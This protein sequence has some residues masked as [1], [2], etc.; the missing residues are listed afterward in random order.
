MKFASLALVLMLV[1]WGAAAQAFEAAGKP[2][3]HID[4]AAAGSA[5]AD[6]SLQRPLNSLDQL[7]AIRFAP[8]TRIL[9]KRGATCHGSFRPKAGSSGTAAT[10][11]V[12][13]S[14][15]NASAPRAAIAAGCRDAR[16]DPQ[17][18]LT[19]AS[20]RP[21]GV[22]PYHSLCTT[23]DGIVNRAAVHLL[24]VEYW[25]I[26]GLELSNDGLDEAGRVGLLVQLENFGTGHHYRINDVYVHH[27]RGYLKDE[28]NRK[29]AYK[30]TGGILFDVTRDGELPGAKQKHTNFD[31]VLVENSEVYHV[32]GIG[33]SNR[34]AW[35]CRPR[36]APCGDFPPYKG[37]P[38]Y[39][40]DPATDAATDFYPST[41][42]VFRNNKIHDIGGDGLIVRTALAPLVEAN[43]LHDIWMRAPGNSAGAWAINTDGAVFQY[44]EVHG[45]RLPAGMN[46]GM[47]FD[48]DM[49]TRQTRI[50]ANYSHD[51]AGGLMLFCAC[52]K[53]GLGQQAMTESVVVER[54]L[55]INDRHR[56]ILVA[57][58]DS[59]V[60][61]DN[62]IVTDSA[63]PLLESHDYG[64]S[65]VLEMRGNRFVS[66]GGSGELY[67]PNSKSGSYA[68]FVW[69]DNT[70]HGYQ[71]SVQG[72]VAMSAASVDVNSLVAQW[73]AATQFRQRGYQPR[74]K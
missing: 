54:N 9:F 5:A 52:G 25:E 70:F 13:D 71:A 27:V 39:L 49:G 73:F 59:A 51:N 41:R 61:I 68:R 44:N 74:G 2:V 30:A 20:M 64:T 31:D 4:C 21:E 37:N 47:A 19:K 1:G 35:L 15:G 28:P 67:R 53:D 18:A 3:L 7:N 45:V 26:N 66:T 58:L 29:L 42:L 22:S 32:D 24:N 50:Y 65:D 43:L 23:D 8:G 46:D 48:A 16:P 60:V 12:V 11:I 34:S 63:T 14:Y 69:R 40:T 62:L 6:G 56:L 55:S 38:S 10:P 36:G 57:G 72:G 17:Q 33:L